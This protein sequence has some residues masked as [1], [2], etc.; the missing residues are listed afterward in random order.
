MYLAIVSLVLAIKATLET[1][2]IY[3]LNRTTLV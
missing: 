1:I 3:Y 2:V